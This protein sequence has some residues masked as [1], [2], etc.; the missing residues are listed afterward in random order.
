[1]Y[2]FYKYI[3]ILR[4]QFFSIYSEESLHYKNFTQSFNTKKVFL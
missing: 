4:M 1:M 3:Y 2:I